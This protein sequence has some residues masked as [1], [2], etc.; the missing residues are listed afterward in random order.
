MIE[1]SC[2]YIRQGHYFISNYFDFERK[3]IFKFAIKLSIYISISSHLNGTRIL[4]TW[5]LLKQ[6]TCLAR[7]YTIA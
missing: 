7:V 4:Y 3:S 5:C 2:L 1:F 6:W